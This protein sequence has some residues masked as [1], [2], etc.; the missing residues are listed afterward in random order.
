MFLGGNA[1][2]YRIE[3]L[4]NY[5]NTWAYSMIIGQFNIMTVWN[6]WQKSTLNLECFL[7]VL[8]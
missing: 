3:C 5:K 1:T 2:N 8:F 4:V 7:F 6:M